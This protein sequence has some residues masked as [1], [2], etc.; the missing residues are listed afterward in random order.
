MYYSIDIPD[1]CLVANL[2]GLKQE[3]ASDKTE[4]TFTEYKLEEVRAMLIIKRKTDDNIIYL[5]L[6]RR[7]NSNG[8]TSTYTNGRMA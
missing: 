1:L 3:V 7:F 5:S 4:N 6:F 2:N 8:K